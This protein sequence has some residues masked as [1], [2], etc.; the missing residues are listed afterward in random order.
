MSKK[1]VRMLWEAYDT[2]SLVE[3]GSSGFVAIFC[4][5]IL[6]CDVALAK[7]NK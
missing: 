1:T 4:S 5:L 7:L 2:D 6:T 3:F